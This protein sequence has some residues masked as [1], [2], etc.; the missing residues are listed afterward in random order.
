ME[1]F[2]RDLEAYDNLDQKGIVAK[3]NHPP[4]VCVR[5]IVNKV[6]HSMGFTKRTDYPV[7]TNVLTDFHLHFQV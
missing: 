5:S 4:L 1:E 3:Q 6:E 7:V 2:R